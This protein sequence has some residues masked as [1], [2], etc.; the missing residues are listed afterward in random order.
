ME[1]WISTRKRIKFCKINFKMF[2][3]KADKVIPNFFGTTAKKHPQAYKFLVFLLT[4][5][6]KTF[7]VLLF[8]H[9]TL[10]Y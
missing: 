9:E 1:W 6:H 10:T 8:L 5:D 4:R 2:K 7:K 3:S